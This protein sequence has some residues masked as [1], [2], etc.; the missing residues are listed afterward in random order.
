MAENLKELLRNNVSEKRF[1]HSQGVAEATA[2]ILEHYNCLNYIKTFKDY[3]AAF[4]CGYVHDLGREMTDAQVIVYCI[5][6][7]IKL[8]Q[9]EL[10][11]PMLAH[12][13]IAVSKIEKIV[14]RIPDSWRKAIEIHT[15]GDRG[16]DDLALALF[17]ADFIEPSRVYLTDKQREAFLNEPSIEACAYAVLMTE[18]AHWVEKNEF[19]ISQQSLAMKA[20]LED[21]L[22]K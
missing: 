14:G 8:N 16:M 17:I 12:G 7:K 20:D 4:F 5:E 19:S 15:L 22:K 6:N 13:K 9:E 18:N 3:E 21:R 2:K 10:D 1:I 11:R